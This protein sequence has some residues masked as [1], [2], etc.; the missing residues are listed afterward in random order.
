MHQ[1]SYKES[2]EKIKSRKW[3]GQ[4]SLQEDSLVH[5]LQVG[6][7]AAGMGFPVITG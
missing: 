7:R 2:L 4:I 5:R 1:K 6:P 3:F